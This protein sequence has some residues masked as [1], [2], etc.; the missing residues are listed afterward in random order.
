VKYLIFLILFSTSAFAKE[1]RLLEVERI[2]VDT[3]KI[4]NHRNMYFPYNDPDTGGEE[5]VL[6]SAFIVDLNIVAYN[7]WAFYW[8]NRP[9]M[10]A[11]NVQV[12]E[13]GWEWETG[14]TYWKC[15]D[16][17]WYHLSGHVLDAEVPGKYPLHNFYG[18]RVTF[19]DRERKCW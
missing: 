2:Q 8:R 12:R 19:Y 9:Y 16:F 11:T 3:W 4:E 18:A 1:W 14:I 6:G 13:A 10:S 17:Y 15:V 7:K 5:W